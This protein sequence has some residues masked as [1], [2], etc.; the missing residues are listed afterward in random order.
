[1]L[2]QNDL[3]PLLFNPS[4]ERLEIKTSPLQPLQVPLKITT[5]TMIINNSSNYN[6]TNYHNTYD[7]KTIKAASSS[8]SFSSISSISSSFLPS[9]SSSTKI[10]TTATNT[11]TFNSYTLSVSIYHP[12]SSYNICGYI[13]KL[14]E[15]YLYNHH[16][17]KRKYFILIN[18]E[19]NYYDN[20]YELDKKKGCILC[21]NIYKIEF[22]NTYYG[23]HT[24][25]IMYTDSNTS[26]RGNSSSSK[27]SKV[28]YVD[29]NL[30]PVIDVTTGIALDNNNKYFNNNNNSYD[31]ANNENNKI[32]SSSHYIYDHNYRIPKNSIYGPYMRNKWL[33]VL[34]RNCS[35]KCVDQSMFINNKNNK[36]N[37][38]NTD[39]NNNNSNEKRK[40]KQMMM[41]D[42]APVSS[43]TTTTADNS[44][45]TTTNTTT[46]TTTS[47]TITS[48]TNTTT[49]TALSSISNIS[50][51]STNNMSISNNNSSSGVSTT[52]PV[53]DIPTITG[54]SVMSNSSVIPTTTSTTPTT[55]LIAS[56]AT[57][58]TTTTLAT[59]TIIMPSALSDPQL[60]PIS[61][62]SN[63]INDPF[64]S[65]TNSPST[66]AMIIQTPPSSKTLSTVPQLA[67]T[68]T[69]PSP[70]P[71][72]TTELKTTLQSPLSTKLS[73]E[74]QKFSLQTFLKMRKMRIPD[75]VIREK[76]INNDYSESEIDDFFKD[77]PS[78]VPVS[79]SSLNR[80]LL[81]SP[82]R[83]KL[84]ESINKLS[85]SISTEEMNN[86]TTQQSS[87]ATTVVLPLSTNLPS[88]KQKLSLQTFLKMR[89]MRIPDAAIREKMINNDY[90]ESEIDDF[91]KD[92]PSSVPVSSSSLN[93]ALR[94]SP[95]RSK[96]FE[97]IN[98]LK[99]DD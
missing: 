24:I 8:S 15:N 72:P 5:T 80:A 3:I 49:T 2:N 97:S 82:E 81:H 56:T 6:T 38:N 88:E 74:N 58:S 62:P 67:I 7:T 92:G 61:I 76:M 27:G 57:T 89:K 19:L 39:N 1:M 71:P 14:S 50:N 53:D 34:L 11:T 47:T 17:W 43:T 32:S 25:K 77:G 83:L 29:F 20:E 78:S 73:L 69:S 65:I 84:F 4:C 95:E 93:R 99:V 46:N 30:E 42:T 59:T 12:L 70:S 90:S 96:L 36:N 79:S 21:S 98:K 33:R 10:K 91:F 54:L 75:A 9:S 44:S 13:Y 22:I 55:T 63:F 66:E 26:S 41:M 31:S 68:I 85:N 86:Q 60:V 16:Q 23:H 51:L 64:S 18:N 37:N 35:M 94:H 28:M 48:T 52:L 45:T 87:P 40:E